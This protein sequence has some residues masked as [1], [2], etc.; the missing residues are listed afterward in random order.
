M[1]DDPELTELLRRENDHYLNV[2]DLIAASNAPTEA[3]RSNAY[4]GVAQFRSA[5]GYPGRRPYAGT[6]V[7][8][9][10]E[11]L[12]VR[13]ACTVFGAEYANV[14][15]LSGS[16]A[17]LAAFNAVLR[18]GETLMSMAMHAGG[19]LSHGHHKHVSAS[20]YRPVHYTVDPE[21]GLLDFD[22]ILAVAKAERPAAIVCGFSA[23]PRAIDFTRFAE[24]AGEVNARLIADISHIAGLVAAGLHASPGPAGAIVTTSVEK[25]LR[26]TRGGLILAPR[27]LA[28]PIDAAVFPGLQSSIGLAGLVS[29]CALL[30]EAGGAE[31]RRYQ[32]RVVH[33]ARALGS[34][35]AAHG[36]RLL[37][38]GTDTHLLVLDVAAAGL[39]GR[40]AEQRLES[41][42][43]LANR[44]LLPYDK[45]PPFEAS[46]L[47]LGTPTI[48]ARGY[49]A[50][51]VDDLG[52][53]IAAA[54]L[55]DG[56]GQA[57]REDLRSRVAR[58][59]STARHGDLLA[60]L[61]PAP[62]SA[63]APKNGPGQ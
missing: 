49:Q 59:V 29:L 22:E 19:H 10:I 6:G 15:P 54:L 62:K 38:G 39:T 35:L 47:R 23:Y 1:I 11:R 51:D 4:W 30:N 21:T 20:L 57:R 61:A 27:E 32:Q 8:D 5:E 50:E 60:D 40:Q 44:N 2:V 7:F 18:P 3:V 16:L 12:A 25:T 9:E 58:H 56:W 14:Q 37:T 28:R 36:I 46:G 33:N 13:R 34:R 24:I 43:I 63:P 45:N 52:D 48:T 17:N 55:A 53:I 26:G 42:A 31:F 41:I